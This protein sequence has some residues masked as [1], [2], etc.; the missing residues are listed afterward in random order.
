[1]K[2]YKETINNDI[3]LLSLFTD[4]NMF[5]TF[6]HSR[7]IWVEKEEAYSLQATEAYEYPGCFL[8]F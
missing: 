1:M 8:W 6:T 2:S 7:P 5:F 3:L 4:F